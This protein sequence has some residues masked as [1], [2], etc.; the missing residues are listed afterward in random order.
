MSSK[1]NGSRKRA[2]A[3][4]GL[5]E[6]LD[7]LKPPETSDVPTTPIGC[8][9]VPDSYRGILKG[10][11]PSHVQFILQLVRPRNPSISAAYAKAYPDC[12]LATAYAN[13]SKLLKSA[14]ISDA[15]EKIRA[16]INERVAKRLE[17]NEEKLV[18]E[19]A[20]IAYV[21]AGDIGTWDKD[22]LILHSSEDLPPELTAA[23]ES[24]RRVETAEG[25]RVEVKFHDKKGALDSLFRYRGLFNDKT[26]VKF[27]DLD[28][29]MVAIDGKSRGLP[30][31]QGKPAVA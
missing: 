22:T 27:T 13:G 31:E 7:K 12:V 3:S 4:N 16:L 11:K 1:K 21:D 18:A 23:I 6:L 30:S 2:K 8:I 17:V 14:K 19:M 25:V 9:D 20:K 29:L 24:I 15:V 10:L 26:E 5:N 28:A